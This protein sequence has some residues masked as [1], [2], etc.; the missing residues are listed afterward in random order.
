MVVVESMSKIKIIIVI[1][2]GIVVG[3]VLASFGLGG[4]LIYIEA[5]TMQTTVNGWSTSLDYGKWDGNILSRAAFSQVLP[6]GNVAEEA[7]YWTTT[8]DSTGARLNGQHD[9]ILHF[10]AGGLPPNDAFWSLT[11]T[12]VTNHMVNN[13]I[14]RYNVG[15]Y[16]NL[17][18]N[19]DGSVDIYLQ[20]APPSGNESNW[21]PAPSGNFKL[22]LRA[23]LPGQAILNGTY[24]VPPV[25]EVS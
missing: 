25:V 23:Y 1:A 12:D 18:P 17:I 7:V 10:P 2:L 19:A 4:T 22:W 20:T 8:V 16:S 3:A 21:L 11:M 13:S 14:N 24:Q 15:T 9:Y 5:H 6:G